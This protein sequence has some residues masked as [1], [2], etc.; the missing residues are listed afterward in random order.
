MYLT[1][2]VKCQNNST[3]AQGL[4]SAKGSNGGIL[5]RETC[6]LY[7]TDVECDAGEALMPLALHGMY[8]KS[9]QG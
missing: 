1:T 7:S 5:F 4:D 8:N 9:G 2:L 3:R 6:L